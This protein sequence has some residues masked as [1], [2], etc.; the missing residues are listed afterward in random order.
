MRGA[1]LCLGEPLA[2]FAERGPSDFVASYG[3]DIS[4]VAVAIAR[5]GGRARILSRVGD[6]IFGQRLRAFWQ[7][8]GVDDALVA[9]APG[10][11]TGICFVTYDAAGHHFSYRRA[12]SA[13]SRLAP[14]GLDGAAIA[15]AGLFYTSGITLAIS[16]TARATA[17]RAVELAR[18]AG[19]PVAVDPNLRT[20]LWPL[21]EARA[22]THA[23]MRRCDIALPGL[24][25]AV[26]L[27]GL[28]EP[29]EIVAFYHDLGAGIVALT[30]GA[31]GVL[32]SDG[33]RREALPGLSVAT[34]DATGAGDCFNGI[35]LAEY[36]QTGDP[37]RAAVLANTGAALSTRGWG[38]I[39]G[40]PDRAEVLRHLPVGQ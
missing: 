28:R 1:I 24:E 30:L 35:F 7:A 22:V 31:D 15:G 18:A 2:E 26:Q 14:E 38:A 12:G 11:D 16:R 3:G 9:V 29:A 33:V 4:N 37:F 36:L 27:T 25:D 20:R 40:I 32:V 10:E 17:E 39:S 5:Q 13:A 23:L 19:V 6:D 21:E 34:V 8:E